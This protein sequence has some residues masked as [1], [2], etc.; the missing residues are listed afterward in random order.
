M[1][2]APNSTEEKRRKSKNK[3]Q[4][5]KNILRIHKYWKEYRE[6]SKNLSLYSEASSSHKIC[7][8]LAKVYKEMYF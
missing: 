8:L 6:E 4:P 1:I 7:I 3:V 2:I 5:M